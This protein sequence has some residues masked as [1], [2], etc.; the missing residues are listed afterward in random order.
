V[1]LKPTDSCDDI[2]KPIKYKDKKKQETAQQAEL[3]N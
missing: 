3:H 2:M 1:Y